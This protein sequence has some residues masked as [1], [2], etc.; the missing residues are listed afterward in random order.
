[1]IGALAALDMLGAVALVVD[2][3]RVPVRVTEKTHEN[4]TIHVRAVERDGD[5]EARPAGGATTGS[6]ART[7]RRE[8]RGRASDD[9]REAEAATREFRVR[10]EWVAGWLDPLV[11][12][13]TSDDDVFCPA[14]SLDAV[15]YDE[16][17]PAGGPEGRRTSERLGM[18]ER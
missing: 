2:G 16:A 9:R 4:R 3:E 11:G 7:D 13:R 15:G 10:T 17:R 1:M 8:D 18:R 12:V 14:G 5:R 6:D